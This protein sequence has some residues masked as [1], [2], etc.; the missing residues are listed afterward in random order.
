[1]SRHPNVR[2][3]SP[4]KRLP[5]GPMEAA[6]QN[7]WWTQAPNQAAFYHR[8]KTEQPRMRVSKYGRQVTLV[9]AITQKD[10][11]RAR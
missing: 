3:I 11:G 6:P 9:T 8:A 1:M 2:S 10:D 5:K 4:H 7:S